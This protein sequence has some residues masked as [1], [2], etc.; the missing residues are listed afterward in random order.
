MWGQKA[1][2]VCAVVFVIGGCK[3]KEQVSGAEQ[4][5]QPAAVSQTQAQT[6]AVSEAQAQTSGTQ[7]VAQAA[8]AEAVIAE[9]IPANAS[10]TQGRALRRYNENAWFLQ[11][12][13]RAAQQSDALNAGILEL[14]RAGKPDWDH[15]NPTHQHIRGAEIS[16][17]LRPWLEAAQTLEPAKRAAAL[18]VADRIVTMEEE[19]GNLE[20]LDSEKAPAGAAD[21]EKKRKSAGQLALANLGAKFSYDSGS[22]RNLYTSNWLREAY[23]L[24]Q[25]DRAGELVFLLLMKSGFNTSPGCEGGEELFRKVLQRGSEYLKQK[26]SPGVEAR[27]HFQMGNAYRDIVALAA[28]QHGDTYANPA[29]YKPEAADAKTKAIAEYRAGLALDDKSYV[30]SVAKERLEALQAGKAPHDTSFYCET[31]D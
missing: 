25:N 27:I 30:A 15:S 9:V 2:A 22:E 5:A 17:R 26:R 24:D 19:D 10:E 8:R 6:A 20:P 18:L 3:A 29:K 13:M 12:A 21:T 16:T 7:Q 1:V 11:D 23:E 4:K 14:L 28:G 31:L